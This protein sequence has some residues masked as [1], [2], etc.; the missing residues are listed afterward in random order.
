M[1]NLLIA[2]LALL[3][4]GLGAWRWQR[5][6]AAD[7]LRGRDMTDRI[8]RLIRADERE[9]ATSVITLDIGGSGKLVYARRDGD[10]RCVNH[11]DAVCRAEAVEG[12]VKMLMDAEGLVRS[13]DVARLADYGLDEARRW[14]VQLCGPDAMTRPD[15]DVR[16]AID[17]G[18]PTAAGD[19]CYVRR[20]GNAA[21]WEIDANPWSL[22]APSGAI[23]PLIDPNVVPQAWPKDSRRIDRIAVER[24]PE[25]FELV[26]HE[27][28]VKEED[29]RRGISPAYWVLTIDGA[30]VPTSEPLGM[31]YNTFLFRIPA[32]RLL[33]PTTAAQRGLDRPVA[34]VILQAH[35]GKSGELVI[36][37]NGADGKAAVLFTP[38]GSLFEIEAVVAAALA[39]DAAVFHEGSS[40]NP[41]Q[42]FL[43]ERP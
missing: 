15:N 12:L 32:L 3:L 36:G 37:Q 2:W 30:D 39:P 5:S 16:M 23:P 43:S 4:I 41:W 24:G 1:K 14:R 13:T 34:R 31:T 21:V 8:G 17:V 35:D 29:M 18:L 42:A 11:F 10:W 25:H 38:T 7:E 40:A 28:E 27:R 26:L 20:Q 22:L 33:D 6:I 19:G 9:F